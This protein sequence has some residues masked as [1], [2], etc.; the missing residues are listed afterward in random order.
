M[1]NYHYVLGCMYVARLQGWNIAPGVY[2]LSEKGCCA[3]GAVILTE[4]GDGY[5]QEDELPQV[6]EIQRDARAVERREGMGHLAMGFDLEFSELPEGKD[7]DRNGYT[8]GVEMR[9]AVERRKW[10]KAG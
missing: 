7:Y 8:L 2:Y 1:T 5:I 10:V 9:K 6:S 4:A 3:V